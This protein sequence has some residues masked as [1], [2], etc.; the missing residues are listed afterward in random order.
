MEENI[1]A[2]I[3]SSSKAQGTLIKSGREKE[4]I[5]GSTEELY[6]SEYNIIMAVSKS[7]QL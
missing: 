6:F 7:E 3:S 4:R 5:E 1:R 2:F